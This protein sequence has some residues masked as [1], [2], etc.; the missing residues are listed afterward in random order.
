[1]FTPVSSSTF[2]DAATSRICSM[3]AGPATSIPVTA[4][5]TNRVGSRDRTFSA[6]ARLRCRPVA[7]DPSGISLPMQ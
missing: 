7:V 1:M 5:V 2:R 6:R 4:W 3:I